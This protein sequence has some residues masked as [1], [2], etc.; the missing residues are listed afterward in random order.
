MSDFFNTIYKQVREV[1]KEVIA[2]IKS[3]TNLAAL[4]EAL[5]ALHAKLNH[6][7][8]DRLEEEKKLIDVRV[9]TQRYASIV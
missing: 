2:S 8:M 6:K 4:K 1:E 7:Q 5:D 9:E 3:S